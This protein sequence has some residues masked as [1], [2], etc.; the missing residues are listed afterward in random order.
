MLSIYIK[1][2]SSSHYYLE[3]NFL[4]SNTHGFHKISLPNWL[5]LYCGIP[6]DEKYTMGSWLELF[7]SI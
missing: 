2:R 3:E 5:L 4:V 6:S 1:R 7:I